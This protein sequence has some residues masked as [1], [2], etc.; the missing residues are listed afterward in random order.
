MAAGRARTRTG[1]CARLFRMCEAVRET[2]GKRLA[3]VSPCVTGEMCMLGA[4]MQENAHEHVRA[5]GAH[6]E[7]KRDTR[8]RR[9]S[10]YILSSHLWKT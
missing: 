9:S 5:R 7:R 6:R 4:F 2:E 1:I 8:R 3:A 10:S